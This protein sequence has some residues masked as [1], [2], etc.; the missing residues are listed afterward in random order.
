MRAFSRSFWVSGG[1]HVERRRQRRRRGR[2]ATSLAIDHRDR[3]LPGRRRRLA[4]QLRRNAIHRQPG[5]PAH[6]RLERDDDAGRADTSTGNGPS[7]SFAPAAAGSYE[8]T[9]TV[10]TANG[11]SN[12]A[13]A[14]AAATAIPLFYRQSTLAAAND[15]FVV[16]TV[17]SDGGGAHQLSC[18]VNIADGSGNGDGGAGNRG[19]YADTPGAFG[20]RVRYADGLPAQIVFENVT[21]TEHQLLISDE[22]GDCTPRRRCA[23]TPR[24]RHSTWCRASRRRARGWRGSTSACRRVSS[25]RRRAPTARRATRAHGGQAEVGAAAVDR[26]DARGVGGRHG[27]LGDAAPRDCLGRRQRRHRRRRRPQRARRLH[28]HHRRHG[29]A[30]DHQFDSVG[31]VWIA[32]G[33]IKSRT[34][35]PPGA[36]ILYRLAGSSC[37][38]TAA[39]VLADE[40]AGGFA[41]DFAVSPDGATLVF[42]GAEAT[43]SSAQISS[44]CSVDGSV[45]PSRF[46]GS[47]PGLDDIGPTWIADGKQL[48]WTQA[49]TDNT[50]TGG[51]L[52]VANR[53]GSN[54]RS[55]LAQ[56]GSTTAKVFVVG[57][58]NRGL[59]CSAAGG[60]PRPG[61]ALLRL[62]ARRP[63]RRRRDDAAEAA[64]AEPRRLGRRRRSR[65][66]RLSRHRVG[67]ARARQPRALWRS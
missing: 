34:A 44:S 60:A 30:G 14:G 51:G 54:V 40:P 36:T 5:P 3:Q 39:T 13:K 52:M 46:I 62:R 59:D 29:D 35:N 63:V 61:E 27:E 20:T 58:A 55:V 45:A 64:Q 24:R 7:F 66:P 18:P 9:L 31:G 6:L 16:G 49:P 38:T 67:R 53:D 48:T 22:N 32:S 8:V 25:S 57:P 21:A 10:S 4:H 19:T 41:W 15:A 43:G 37:S 42:A 28:R 47:S 2:A 17:G 50:A 11:D 23:S 56:G 26:R 65:L 33:G 12:S 1:L